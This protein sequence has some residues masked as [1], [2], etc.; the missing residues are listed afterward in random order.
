MA[1]INY[2]NSIDLG[3]INR[4]VNTKAASVTP[5][6]FPGQDANLTEGVDSL[7]IIAYYTITG[8]IVGSFEELQN[9]LYN[10]RSILD[11]A[12]ISSCRLSSPFVN[13]KYGDGSERRQGHI[14]VSKGIVVANYLTDTDANFETWNIQEESS[15]DIV[16]N[17]VT[18]SVY[19]ITSVAGQNALQLNT[20]A[21]PFSA[22]GIPYA[23]T[24]TMDVK[25]LNF[26]ATWV[27]PG[28]NMVDYNLS[29]MQVKS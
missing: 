13:C 8:R 24:A 23:V 7:G 20:S 2:L 6:S 21:N 12:Q 28:L 3:K 25:I 1:G 19:Y 9:T 26:D 16:K 15:Y 4:W 17:L 5:I 11:G 18:G 10:I 14:G 29:V 22:A 27:T